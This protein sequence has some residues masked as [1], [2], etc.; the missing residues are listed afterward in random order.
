MVRKTPKDFL[1]PD[2]DV[3]FWFSPSQISV[4]DYIYLAFLPY[5]R[6]FMPFK[7][8]LN[9]IN[10][11]AIDNAGSSTSCLVFCLFQN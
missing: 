4:I 11:N 6:R 8:I 10:Q 2:Y 3:I 7:I 9:R 1:V 5:F